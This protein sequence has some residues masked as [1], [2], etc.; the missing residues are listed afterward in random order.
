MPRNKRLRHGAR[1]KISAYEKFFET[2]AAISSRCPNATK[3]DVLVDDLLVIGQEEQLVS[4]RRQVYLRM[5][6]NASDDGQI[7][8]VVDQSNPSCCGPV[9][10]LFDIILMHDVEIFPS[11]L[12]A[13]RVYSSLWGSGD[14]GQRFLLC[15][16]GSD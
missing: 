12:D 3:N 15:A 9:K 11:S 10:S 6:H 16:S 5:Q 14:H 13:D 2:R 7:L 8:H 4:N 1:A